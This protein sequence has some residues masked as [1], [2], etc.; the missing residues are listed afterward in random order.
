MASAI[1]GPGNIVLSKNRDEFSAATKHYLPLRAA[2]RCS[3][4]GC[5]ALTAGPSDESP[6]AVIN[7]GVAAHIHA[8]A[9][10]GRRYD[11]NMTPEERKDIRNG[12]W[13]CATHGTEID[14]DEVRYTPDVL[15]KIKQDHESRVAIELNGGKGAFRGS[16]LIAIGPY[17]VGVGELLGTSG[18]EWIVRVDHFIEGDLRK[19]IKLGERF[20]L[21]DPYDRYLIVNALG[22]GRQLARCPSWQRSGASIELT[23][24]VEESF[25]RTDACVFR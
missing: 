24:S 11:L 6:D 14:R 7:V 1:T 20:D 18:N 5:S 17:I 4:T 9:P 19:L 10:G 21:I 12:I 3:M 25:P 15:R 8:A 13:L 22:D 16:D 2:Y 23:C